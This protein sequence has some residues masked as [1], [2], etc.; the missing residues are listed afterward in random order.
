MEKV[1]VCNLCF[2][3][4]SDEK[5]GVQCSKCFRCFHCGCTKVES[6]ITR[7]FKW[8]CVQCNESNAI[9]ELLN[10]Q[11]NDISKLMEFANKV[12]KLSEDLS[13]LRDGIPSMISKEVNEVLSSDRIMNQMNNNSKNETKK[14]ILISGLPTSIKDSLEL[15]NLIIKACSILGVDI[16][17][18]DIFNCHWLG[19]KK[20]VI[21]KFNSLLIRDMVMKKYFQSKNLL[22]SQL[23]QGYNCESRVYFNNNYPT[24]TRR[25]LL[26]SRKL[27]KLKLIQ[28]FKMDFKKSVINVHLKDNSSA[29]F[30]DFNSLRSS[31]PIAV[32]DLS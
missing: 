19:D 22:L 9:L 5:R 7:N 23:L 26:Y 17:L 28:D 15:S 30:S 18:N 31:F 32:P 3:K 4:L 14:D 29:S 24:N 2:A 12:D 13:V 10:T 25:L 8:C 21:I 16:T 27:K 11:K 1:G 6:K 20:N